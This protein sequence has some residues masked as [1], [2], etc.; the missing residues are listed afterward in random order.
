MLLEEK[1][2]FRVGGER[3]IKIEGRLIAAT[4]KDLKNLLVKENLEKICVLSLKCSTSD[5]SSL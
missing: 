4:N 1:Q 5:Y 3:P 2:I